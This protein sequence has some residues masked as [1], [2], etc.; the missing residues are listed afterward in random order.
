M[1]SSVIVETGICVE[2]TSAVT[3]A[4]PSKLGLPVLLGFAAYIARSCQQAHFAD[5]WSTNATFQNGATD[6]HISV[7][8]MFI[9]LMGVPVKM[10]ATAMKRDAIK[11]MN[12]V[13]K[14]LAKKPGVQLTV[15]TENSTPKVTVLA[16]VV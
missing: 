14:S 16:T 1:E 3:P 2:Q 12:S 13:S 11:E 5:K 7:L 8:M 6:S 10:V 15:A 9:C 4:A